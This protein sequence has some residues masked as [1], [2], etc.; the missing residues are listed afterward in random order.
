MKAQAMKNRD[1]ICWACQGVTPRSSFSAGR[2]GMKRSEQKA[3]R[4]PI[5]ASSEVSAAGDGRFMVFESPRE[6]EEFPDGFL[7]QGPLAVAGGRIEVADRADIHQA[8]APV[9]GHA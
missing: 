6:S 5:T 7:G 8:A 9:L 1:T 4:S 3:L 2:A